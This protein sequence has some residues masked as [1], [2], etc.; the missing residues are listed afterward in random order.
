M[1]KKDSFVINAAKETLAT[2]KGKYVYPVSGNEKE[3]NDILEKVKFAL[4]IHGGRPDFVL[5][6]ALYAGEDGKLV[7]AR[8]VVRPSSKDAL[9][10]AEC[11]KTFMINAGEDFFNKF[12]DEMAAWFDNYQYHKQLQANIDE[13]NAVVK[14]VSAENEIPFVVTFALGD[15]LLDASEE[16]AVVGL[17]EEVI[18]D[19]GNLPLFDEMLEARKVGYRA[20]IA[21]TLKLC[22]KPY[23]IVKV[24]TL[25]TKD[26]DIYSRRALNKLMREFVSRKADFVRVG[27]GYVDTET[28]FAVVEKEAVAEAAL[29]ALDLT[30]ALVIDNVAMTTQDKKVGANKIV[31]T[32]KVAP[33]NKE[34]AEP[35]E[36]KLEDVVAPVVAE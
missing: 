4:N 5:T 33:F 35:V 18:A 16:Y 11:K 20:K 17:S 27:V 15:G 22:A 30:N 21:E 14:E 26:L 28:Y 3:V 34:T 23:S 7:N 36:V 31:V 1:F 13:L 24:K 32:F 2:L 8:F 12:I 9:A 6:R 10:I 19:L 25:V 29:E